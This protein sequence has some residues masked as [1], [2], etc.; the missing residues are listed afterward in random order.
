[1]KQAAKIL[2]LDLPPPLEAILLEQLTSTELQ[3]STN[4]ADDVFDLVISTQ[5]T[6]AFPGCP[7]LQL[8]AERPLHLGGLLRRIGQMLA[9]PTLY[10]EDIP[11]GPWIFKVQER[12]LTEQDGAGQDIALTDREVD[13]LAYLARHQG[14]P[15]SRE[16]LL[17][18]VWRYQ[19]GV[20]THTLE[21][22]IYRL[23]QKTGRHDILVTEEGGYHLFKEAQNAR[24]PEKGSVFIYILAAVF[25]IGLLVFAMTRGPQK[26]AVSGQADEMTNLAQADVAAII[27]DISECMLTYPNKVDVNADGIDDFGNPNPP[28]PL[29]DPAGTSGGTGAVLTNIVCPGTPGTPKLFDTAKGNKLRLIGNTTDFSATYFN[30][31]TNGVYFVIKRLTTSPVWN[32]AMARLDRKY[33]GCKATTVSVG[34][35]AKGCFYYF[36][37][38]PTTSTAT[39]E[40]GCP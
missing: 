3:I 5:E 12:I 11:F 1:M 27:T 8:S 19:D 20:D 7:V 35:C 18:H 14:R 15:V 31:A 38:L 6:T 28:Y 17:K 2:L 4:G 22:H 33:P 21:T 34:A 37:V 25:M 23:R 16:D 24:Q 26:G 30:D 29:Y 13:M 9:E 39:S 32:E 36:M 40:A 10:L